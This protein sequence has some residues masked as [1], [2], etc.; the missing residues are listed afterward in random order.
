MSE[1]DINDR[2]DH[3]HTCTVGTIVSCNGQT[4]SVKPMLDMQQTDGNSLPAPV[5][6]DVPVCYMFS[7][8]DDARV[9]VPIKAGDNCLVVFAQRSTE[10]WKT[11]GDSA[12]TMARKHDISDAFVFPILRPGSQ[13]ASTEN[14]E[15]MM[16]NTSIKITPSGEVNIEA[17]SKATIKAP[18]VLID[19]PTTITKLLTLQGGITM[20][21]GG[22]TTAT[23]NGN[24]QINGNTRTT[25][26][27]ET[28]G[29]INATG[30][31]HG[32][33]I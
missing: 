26:N 5:L 14:I 33:N 4:C 9:T 22:D 20:G 7:S 8:G 13:A 6:N 31:I 30:E 32:A 28:S 3:M 24:I 2:L 11:G 16:K 10:E 29:N 25:G 17:E 15:I 18:E 27:I 21:G 1:S 12:Q 23:L 19:A